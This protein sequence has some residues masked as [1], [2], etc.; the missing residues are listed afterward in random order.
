MRITQS[1][2]RLNSRRNKYA[3]ARRASKNQD[4]DNARKN[5]LMNLTGNRNL[6]AN[7]YM[8]IAESAESLRSSMNVLGITGKNSVFENAR[9]T[10]SKDAIL[11]QAKKMVSSYNATLTG[12]EE[13]NSALSRVYKRLME[14]AAIDNKKALSNIG[15]TINRDKT[16]KIDEEKFNNASLDDIEAAIGAKSSFTEEVEG[17][18]ENISKNAISTAS[19]MNRIND[20]LGRTPSYNSYSMFGNETSAYLSALLSESSRDFWG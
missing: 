2:I 19:N 20:L 1:M 9:N 15:I 17:M 8:K 5:T 14:G 3:S 16:L 12:M 7:K 10:E 6:S 18:A 11:S 4:T 13:D